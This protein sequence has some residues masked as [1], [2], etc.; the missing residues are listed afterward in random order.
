MRAHRKSAHFIRHELKEDSGCTSSA[1]AGPATPSP[2]ADYRDPAGRGPARRFPSCSGAAGYRNR[3]EGRYNRDAVQY[4]RHTDWRA[5]PLIKEDL[6][7]F[8]GKPLFPERPR[9][10]VPMTLAR[11]RTLYDRSRRRLLDE[12]R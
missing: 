8:E 5:A 6:R 2:S 7:T 11:G 10:H 12:P 9:L 3:F 4:G 1:T